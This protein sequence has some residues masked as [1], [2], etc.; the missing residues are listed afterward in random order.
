M[1]GIRLEI[2]GNSEVLEFVTISH[3]VVNSIFT[4]RAFCLCQYFIV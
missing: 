1:R 3:Y 4:I 2:D